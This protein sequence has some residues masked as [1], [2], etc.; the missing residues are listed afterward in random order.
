MPLEKYLWKQLF[1]AFFTRF[2]FHSLHFSVLLGRFSGF[3]FN[4]FILCVCPCVFICLCVRTEIIC[5]FC[6]N[7]LLVFWVFLFLSLLIFFGLF[8]CCFCFVLCFYSVSFLCVLVCSTLDFIFLYISRAGMT[9]LQENSIQSEFAHNFY[10]N[11]SDSF[12]FVI[13]IVKEGI[14]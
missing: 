10:R 2:L 5:L 14:F 9:A 7:F 3:N 12:H 13:S 1:P 8:C 11:S 6:V 4:L